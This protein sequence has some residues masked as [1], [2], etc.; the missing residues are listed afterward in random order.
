M[1]TVLQEMSGNA[2]NSVKQSFDALLFPRGVTGSPD[3]KFI[4]EGI[5]A[6]V[7]TSESVISIPKDA[8]E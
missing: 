1:P 2:H 6:A 7:C 8:H 5:D 3:A 4:L